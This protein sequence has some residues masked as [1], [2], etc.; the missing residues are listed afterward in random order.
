MSDNEISITI[1]TTNAA[2]VVFKTPLSATVEDFKKQISTKLDVA[3]ELQRLIHR[4]RVLKDHQTLAICGV[5]D[6]HAIHLVK[7]QPKPGSTPPSNTNTSGTTNTPQPAPSASNTQS[8]PPQGAM[9]NPFASMMGASAGNG[10][11]PFAAAMGGMGG[12]GGAGMGTGGMPNM[13]QMQQ[14]MMQNPEM[15]QQMMNSP[16]MQSVL[17]NPEI[18]QNMITSNPAMQQ[19]LDANPH[20][21]HV[22]N[23]PALMRQTME[24]MRNPAA[25]REAQRHQDIALSQLEN[26]PE[27]FNALRRM[28][29]DVQ[30]PMMEA[31]RMQQ[32]Q[33]QS[34]GSSGQTSTPRDN[35]SPNNDAL[36][37]P[38]GGGGG[39]APASGTGA[40]G[41]P[42][43]FGGLGGMPGMGAGNAGSMNGMPGMGGL[44]GMPGMGNP[45]QMMQMMQNPQMQQMMQ[46]MMSNPQM[47]DQIAAMDPNMGRML[48]NPQVRAMMTNPAFIQQMTNPANMQAMMQLQQMQSSLNAAGIG[49]APGAGAGAAPG[50]GMGGLPNPFLNMMNNMNGRNPGESAAGGQNGLDFGSLFSGVPPAVPTSGT[51]TS[52]P[53]GGSTIPPA[54]QADP[55]VTYASQIQQLQDMGFTDVAANARAL[56]RTQG[57]VNAAVERLLSGNM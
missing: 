17:N 53:T 25:M 29:E 21:R 46:Q 5:A 56:Q 12:L 2:T 51:P 57:N 11:N 42:N 24:M 7:G 28:Y 20:M 54:P 43:M 9:P 8:V 31:A 45:Q 50:M 16:M 48:Q 23:D 32:A 40:G 35:T 33:S 52:T 10:Q 3:P 55:T 4:G 1:K 38:W 14:Q 34:P 30:E 6:G 18:M 37:N 15:V 41:M 44:G 49:G 27:G 19:M 36:P 13:Q 22:L 26:H 39:S 47:L